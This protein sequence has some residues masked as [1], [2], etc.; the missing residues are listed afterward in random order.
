MKKTLS[1]LAATLIVP[2]LALAQEQ[3]KISASPF[4]PAYGQ[5]VKFELDAG[6]TLVYL[7][8]TRYSISGSTIT[9]DYDYLSTGFGPFGPDFGQQSLS[10]GEIAP[11]NY[12]VQ[13]RLFDIAEPSSSPKVV[14]GSLAVVPPGSWGLYTIPA[15]PQAAAATSIIVKSAAYFDPASMR[16][17]VSGKTVRVN[18]D[19]F[20]AAPGVLSAPEGM[21]T[22]GAAAIPAN[23][24]PG[25]YTVEGW[26]R[27]NGGAYEKFFTQ[28]M[29]VAATTPVVEYYSPSLEHYFMAMGSDEIALLDRGAQGDWKRTGQS[30]KAWMRQ[31][32]A[33][34]GAQ[35]VCRFYARGPNSHFF[36]GNRDECDYLKA[37]EQQGRADA[38]AA[39]KP[40]LG[41]AYEGI[42]FYALM[43]S[44]GQCP[45]GST[46][47]MRFYNNRWMENDSNHRFAIDATQQM[48]MSA[49]WVPEGAQFCSAP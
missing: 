48:A 33:A 29:Q 49:S 4:L 1:I 19:Y 34:S 13:A 25:N 11:G 26:G 30:F 17:T 42:A 18:F 35:P 6:G 39:G 32:D 20:S 2:A 12:T 43:P 40:F 37:A 8:A 21:R 14:Q 3:P 22:Y 10:I 23:L 16:V 46:P 38:S 7:P 27:T 28:S 9:I 45:T 15:Q 5:S 47:V 24:L 41:W 44:N 31:Q 36:T